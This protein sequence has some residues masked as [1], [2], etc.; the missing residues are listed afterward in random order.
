M[1]ESV[2]NVAPGRTTGA[3]R[4]TP[5]LFAHV[6][7]CRVSLADGTPRPRFAGCQ[8]RGTVASGSF[9]AEFVR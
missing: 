3:T 2:C 5:A 6:A 9:P 8:L 1:N 4:P 7:T